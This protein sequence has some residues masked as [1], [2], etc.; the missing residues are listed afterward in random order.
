[1]EFLR[2]IQLSV[3]LF[4]S[5]ACGVLILLTT[6]TKTMTAS[7]RRALV[8]MQ[9]VSMLLLIFDRFAYIYRGDVSTTGYWMVRISNF[10]VFLFSL[11]ATHSFNLYL[12]DLYRKPEKIGKVPFQLRINEILF[13]IG[14]FMLIIAQFN[15]FY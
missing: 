7:R 5:G 9:V 1:M 13:T 12:I 15:G 14:L 4:F 2:T 6:N 10:C 3:M 8:Y 11:A